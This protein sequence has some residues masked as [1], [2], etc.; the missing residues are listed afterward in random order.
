LTAASDSE[1]V[2]TESAAKRNFFIRAFSYHFV[3]MD[4]TAVEALPLNILLSYAS[5][6]FNSNN[7]KYF[8]LHYPQMYLF[9][10]ILQLTSIPERPPPTSIKPILL[11]PDHPE[12][13]PTPP[14]PYRVMIFA[15][16]KQYKVKAPDICR[17]LRIGVWQ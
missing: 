12:Y 8:Q 3:N 1:A 16:P 14:P 10:N 2:R 9:C 6:H 15:K 7:F 5:H 4:G 17:G 11:Q 13:Y